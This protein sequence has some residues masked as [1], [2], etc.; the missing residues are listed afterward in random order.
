MKRR[1]F[2]L[3]TVG[4][5]AAMAIRAVAD[6]RKLQG[7]LVRYAAPVSCI[8]DSHVNVGFAYDS[9]PSTRF[10]SLLASGLQTAL[11]R[12]FKAVNWGFSGDT[13]RSATYSGTTYPGISN[14]LGC[15][16]GKNYVPAL[17][18]L[19]GTTNNWTCINAGGS[20]TD[21]TSATTANVD[22]NVTLV[23]LKAIIDA[24]V[25]FGVQR[26]IVGGYHLRNFSTG[27]DVTAGV[28]NA[29][30]SM[31]GSNPGTFGHGC[32]WAQYQ[33]ALYGSTTYP[34]KVAFC[35]FYAAFKTRLE[36]QAPA[37]IGVD[38]YLHVATQNTHL[39]DRGNQW[40]ADAISS[41]VQAQSGWSAALQA[42]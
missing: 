19:Y 5:S 16:T 30:P 4:A 13:T 6:P 25:A 18:V 34:G 20:F 7:T 27:G 14:R 26:I 1:D 39:N 36:S 40:I 42:V 29:E 41:T 32:R 21:G 24:L 35:D 8:G 10:P 23:D 11:S 22:E 2:L 31:T 33:A 15:I 9:L 28:I 37:Q 12:N 38:T 3:S 17:V